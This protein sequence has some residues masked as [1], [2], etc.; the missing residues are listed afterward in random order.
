MSAFSFENRALVGLEEAC[1]QL[2]I[3]VKTA[4]NLLAA[5]RFPIKTVKLGG[6]RMVV[7]ADLARFIRS[8]T[9]DDDTPTTAT[10]PPARRGR[11]RP[12]KVAQEGG[13]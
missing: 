10:E 6:R 2:G 1:A 7:S 11:G 5:D 12:R 8:L 9:G 4:R 13:V 3:A